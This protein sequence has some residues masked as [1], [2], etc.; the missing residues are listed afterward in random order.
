M[1][2]IQTNGIEIEY[3]ESGPR[4]GPVIVLIMGLGMQLVAWPDAFCDGLAARGFRVVRF[5]NRDAGLSTK[6]RSRRPDRDGR[7][8]GLRLRGAAGQAALHAPRHGVRH[9]GS[10]GCA[11][12]RSRAYRRRLHGRHDCADHGGRA[13]RSRPE[14]ELAPLDQRQSCAAGPRTEGVASPHSTAT[15]KRSGER[16]A[17]D[18]GLPAPDRKPRLSD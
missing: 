10:H 5:D 14:L 13:S 11:R 2:T 8:D 16:R 9:G 7:A 12:D 17:G 3:S 6:M 1:T 4:D 15:T 18:H